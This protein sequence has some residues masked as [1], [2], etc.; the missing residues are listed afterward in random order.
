MWTLD[1]REEAAREARKLG[2]LPVLTEAERTAAIATWK[3]RMV[4]EHISSRVFAA[5]LQQLMAAGVAPRWQAK[6]AEAAS[7]ELRHGRQ[8]AAMVHALG[9]DACATIEHLAPVPA[10]D[11]AS[12]LEAALRNVLSISCLSETVAVALIG[13]E[14]LRAEPDVTEGVLS[15][16][17]ADEVRHAALGW[18]LLE[19][20]SAGLDDDV[21]AGLN[22]Y[23]VVAF[24]HL[25]AHELAHLP[26][27]PTPSEAASDVG[28]CDGDEAVAL[29]VETVTDVIVPR[30]EALGF[31]A[32]AA[33][34][35]SGGLEA[36]AARTALGAATKRAS[37]SR[38]PD[39][40]DRSPRVARA[41]APTP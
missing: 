37:C 8:C 16:I 10:H 31:A 5:L 26:A 15:H 21:R 27:G 12:P 9:G 40:D 33:L 23:L 20:L 25:F 3:G 30:L 14:R 6:V 38:A 28:V 32:E 34:A 35:A 18:G 29:F 36:A 39:A 22:A 13:A 17:L 1:L 7:D 2:P 24:R 11:D 19:S 41:Q 4:N